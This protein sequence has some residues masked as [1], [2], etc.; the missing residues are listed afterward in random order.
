MQVKQQQ[1]ELDMEQ[2]TGFNLGKE[3]VKT[4]YCH[5]AHL[6]N[7]YVE[8]TMQNESALHIRWPKYF[9]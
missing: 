2:Q 9:Q 5:T 4:V 1:L 8:H 6:F 7:L 3:D